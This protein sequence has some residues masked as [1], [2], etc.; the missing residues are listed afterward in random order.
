MKSGRSK[1][2]A[3]RGA[4]HGRDSRFRDFDFE[5]VHVTDDY[6]QQRGLEQML[7]EAYQPPFDI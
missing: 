2:L 6:A 1:D 4:E 3:L 7:H 5:P